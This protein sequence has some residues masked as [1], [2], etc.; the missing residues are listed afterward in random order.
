[1]KEIFVNS[2]SYLYKVI[3]YLLDVIYFRTLIVVEDI[4]Q[5]KINIRSINRK[6]LN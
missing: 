1:M 6:E 2:Y 3:I 5:N 4:H